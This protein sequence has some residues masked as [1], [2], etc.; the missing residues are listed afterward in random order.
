MKIALGVDLT[1]PLTAPA[2]RRRIDMQETTMSAQDSIRVLSQVALRV[3]LDGAT[4]D[5]GH[6]VTMPIGF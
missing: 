4:R 2:S 6:G 3:E 5:G 1:G